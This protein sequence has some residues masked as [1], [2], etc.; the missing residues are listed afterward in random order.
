MYVG[1]KPTG[2]IKT[3]P[4]DFV[5]R[6]MHNGRPLVP[7]ATTDIQGEQFECTE[8]VV[9][10][11]NFES[12]RLLESIA[13]ALQVSLENVTSYGK[14][15]KYAVTTQK[16]VIVGSYTPSFSHSRINMRHR[17][18]AL[19]P[20]RP[21]PHEGNSFSI[22]VRTDASRPP[23]GSRF[24]N[25]FGPQR[26]GRG[27]VEVGKFLLTGDDERALGLLF[28]DEQQRIKLLQVRHHMQYKT[29]YEALYSKEYREQRQFMILQWQ[30][31]LWNR[32][33]MK[34]TTEFLPIWSEETASLYDHIW[35][36]EQIDEAMLAESHTF[37]RPVWVDVGQHAIIEAPEGFRH[38]FILRSGAYATSFLSS[39][40]DLTDAS[41]TYKTA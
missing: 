13:E 1:T 36:P 10:K 7:V 15:D 18:E 39:L 6:E 26:F 19:R 8:F 14:K 17:G 3:A 33:A 34:A 4:D 23:E 21:G 27:S 5:V 35:N 24:R 16:I 20:A 22:L 31:Y 2:V 37:N 12:Q 11:H 38:E 9:T 40:Y 30:S 29:V 32:V 25:L 28:D 41:Q